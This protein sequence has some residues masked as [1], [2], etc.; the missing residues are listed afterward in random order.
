MIA[1]CVLEIDESGG[2]DGSLC[3]AIGLGQIAP[4]F[5]IVDLLGRSTG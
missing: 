1:C 4:V 3:A 2:E 5:F